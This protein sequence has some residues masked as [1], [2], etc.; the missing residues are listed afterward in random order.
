MEHPSEIVLCFPDK[1][2]NNNS[3]NVSIIPKSSPK[4]VG[5]FMHN[6]E[7]NNNTH[8][9]EVIQFSTASLENENNNTEEISKQ[10]RI[11]FVELE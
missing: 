5:G 4:K 10:D 7:Q 9:S 2:N 8:I 3:N 6:L 11:A 1:V